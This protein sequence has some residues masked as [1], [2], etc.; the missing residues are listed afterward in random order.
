MR[1]VKVSLLVFLGLSLIGGAV[2]INDLRYPPEWDQIHLGMTRAEVYS[3]IG[4]G[5]GEWQGW[6]GIFWSDRGFLIRNQLELYIDPYNGVSIISLQR[7]SII[8]GEHRLWNVRTE[9]AHPAKP[10]K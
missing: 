3:L 9:Y 7:F 5:G 8:P 1:V 2:V 4:P 10:L 6:S